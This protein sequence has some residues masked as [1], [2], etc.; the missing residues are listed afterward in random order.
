MRSS[1]GLG[2]CVALW[3]SS[4][5]A[6]DERTRRA[7]EEIERQLSSMVTAAP[8]AMR[9]Q[10]EAPG[11]PNH[12]LTGAEL[13]LDGAVLR[14]LPA[15]ALQGPGPFTVFDGVVP[16][17]AH[18]VVLRVQVVD[19]A[20]VMMSESAGYKWKMAT[21]VSFRSE[22]GLKVHLTFAPRE[23]RGE[24]DPKRRYKVVNHARVEMLEEVDDTPLPPPK[25]VAQAAPPPPPTP[26]PV[27]SPPP[28]ARAPEPPPAWKPSRSTQRRHKDPQ[29]KKRE[30]LLRARLAELNRRAALVEAEPS[31]ALRPPAPDGAVAAAA[32]QAPLEAPPPSPPTLK[33]PIPVLFAVTMGLLSVLMLLVGRRR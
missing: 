24:P 32:P 14:L 22:R 1:A 11:N 21:Q 18:T 25:P 19:N 10:L 30:E 23:D 33:V 29:A 2:L 26:A 8:P 27:P 28:V 5:D 6:E 12:A 16:P 20:S 31:V 7:R 3:A 13:A 15:Q 4:A 17:G 9:V